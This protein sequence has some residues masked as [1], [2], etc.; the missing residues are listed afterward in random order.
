MNDEGD[1]KQN[2]NSYH[3]PVSSSHQNVSQ[4]SSSSQGSSES[5][6]VVESAS[7]IYT[8]PE[9][10]TEKEFL[11]ICG[12]RLCPSDRFNGLLE[13]EKVLSIYGETFA[14][15]CYVQ[16]FNAAALAN[17]VRVCRH[18]FDKRNVLIGSQRTKFDM[19]WKSSIQT[20]DR[21]CI[22]SKLFIA[23]CEKNS[24][25][26]VIWMM[27]MNQFNRNVLKTAFEVGCINQHIKIMN[28]L[29]N[30]LTIRGMFDWPGMVNLLI[31]SSGEGKTHSLEWFH[32]TNERMF[33]SVIPA[34]LIQVSKYGRSESLK[35]ILGLNV[36]NH[37]H[38]GTKIQSITVD[39]IH[40]CFISACAGGHKDVGMI[41]RSYNSMNHM[42]QRTDSLEH[43]IF[44]DKD[45]KAFFAAL[46]NK[47]Y[48]ILEW[49]N[50]FK[51]HHLTVN[52]IDLQND[53]DNSVT[54]VSTVVNESEIGNCIRYITSPEC[55]LSEYAI[56]V[57]SPS[58]ESSN[59]EIVTKTNSYGMKI[60]VTNGKFNDQVVRKLFIDS[61]TPGKITQSC[62]EKMFQCKK[63][64][65][66][67]QD[68]K[69][70]INVVIKTETYI[71]VGSLTQI[72]SKCESIVEKDMIAG[73]IGHHINP[74]IKLTY[75]DMMIDRLG[76]GV[77]DK[78]SEVI[79]K[80]MYEADDCPLCMCEYD[81]MLSC[82]HVMCMSCA[83]EWYLIKEK[84][85]NC[86][87]CQKPF[88]MKEGYCLC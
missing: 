6:C 36:A 43:R 1:L 60:A 58:I 65:D 3:S 19:F 86:Y 57:T 68:V 29:Y 78:N 47:R 83:V 14:Q 79:S 77:A 37:N 61:Q 34:M 87:F 39:L 44:T 32:Q 80:I 25:D 62:Y 12:N 26:V 50:S 4:S 2:P 81:M 73:L 28:A 9:M 13:L 20:K 5:W 71:D 66:M 63:I 7:S 30:E 84:P 74:N 10:K 15:N 56:I 46:I 82:G 59:R 72:L 53:S 31:H 48:N 49:L 16:G 64:S 70:I 52:M 27:S 40:Q 33:V 18:I 54:L 88:V 75:K 55:K 45:R 35:M 42:N 11:E 22:D 24:V 41:L 23:C 8:T 67:H 21:G 85:M 51:H 69:Y 38:N 17:D 76:I